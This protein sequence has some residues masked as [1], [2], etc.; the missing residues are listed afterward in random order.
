MVDAGELGAL[1]RGDDE[2]EALQVE[3]MLSLR[4]R[5]RKAGLRESEREALRLRLR[6]LDLLEELFQRRPLEPRLFTA[7]A[8]L[9]RRRLRG[10]PPSS[11][12]S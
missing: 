12:L 8:P 4:R 10:L 9:L 5:H 7:P 11:S 1:L 3:A 6:A 2:A